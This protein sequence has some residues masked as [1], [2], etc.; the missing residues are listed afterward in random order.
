MCVVS[1][2]DLSVVVI[3]V[4]QPACYGHW[5]SLSGIESG[6]IEPIKEQKLKGRP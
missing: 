6:I 1:I 3:S 2:A 4:F 5:L